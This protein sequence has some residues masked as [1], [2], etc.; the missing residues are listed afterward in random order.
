[1][2]IPARPCTGSPGQRRP[3]E[4]ALAS[5]IAQNA[6]FDCSEREIDDWFA[7]QPR[8]RLKGDKVRKHFT[9]DDIID[10]TA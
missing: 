2:I 4:N 9:N 8:S 6:W 3:L 10:A 5:P 1:L 7:K